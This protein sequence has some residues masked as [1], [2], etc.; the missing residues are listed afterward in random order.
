MIVRYRRLDKICHVFA[1]RPARLSAEN[2]SNPRAC[3]VVVQGK[4]PCEGR[5][6]GQDLGRKQSWPG[7]AARLSAFACKAKAS[8]AQPVPWQ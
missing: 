8:S 6:F 4:P 2:L 1:K 5:Q 7:H 3:P